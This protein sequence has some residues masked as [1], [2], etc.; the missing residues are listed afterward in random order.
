MYVVI[1]LSIFTMFL[2]QYEVGEFIENPAYLKEGLYFLGAAHVGLILHYPNNVAE[3]KYIVLNTFGV[4][5]PILII[6][7]LWSCFV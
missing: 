2:T 5:L 1:A 4:Y 6:R 3:D 7:N